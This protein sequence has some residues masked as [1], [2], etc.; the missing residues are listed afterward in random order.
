MSRVGSGFT[1]QCHIASAIGTAR[2][3]SRWLKT[4]RI[5]NQPQPKSPEK[6]DPGEAASRRRAVGNQLQTSA[7]PAPIAATGVGDEAI[8][9]ML[10]VAERADFVLATLA[11]PP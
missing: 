1:R 2:D 9:A 8:L 7:S 4:S 11:M 5:S 6:P 10:G 3:P